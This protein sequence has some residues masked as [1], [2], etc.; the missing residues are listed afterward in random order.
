MTAKPA[1]I[2]TIH[3]QNTI[4]MPGESCSLCAMAPRIDLWFTR[5]EVRTRAARHPHPG[6][7]P[8]SYDP[9]AIF[10]R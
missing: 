5:W 10:C 9:R 8:A 6:A 1:A 2:R 3:V 4:R 7:I